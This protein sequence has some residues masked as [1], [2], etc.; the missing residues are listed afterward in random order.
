M[1]TQLQQIPVL[2]MESNQ[3]ISKEKAK[4]LV[5]EKEVDAAIVLPKFRR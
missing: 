2:K 5:K 3:P 1:L 4:E